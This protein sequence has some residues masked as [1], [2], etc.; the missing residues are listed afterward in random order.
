MN[1]LYKVGIMDC[2]NQIFWVKKRI[3]SITNVFWTNRIHVM[4]DE[5]KC[6]GVVPQTVFQ[7]L[8]QRYETERAQKAAA[9]PE[10]E[11]KAQEQMESRQGADR[12]LEIIQHYTEI[13]ELDESILFEL[14]DRIEIGEAR[15]H[16]GTRIQDV[17]VFYRYV[18]CVDDVLVQEGQEAV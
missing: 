13:T 9:L 10:L 17:K 5:D 8:M 1:T 6:T 15:K 14:V 2:G 11:R 12:W 18:G 16:L 7:T 4:N 3:F